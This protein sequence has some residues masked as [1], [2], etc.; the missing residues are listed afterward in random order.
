MLT[1]YQ[2]GEVDLQLICQYELSQMSL[3]ISTGEVD[4]PDLTV[5]MWICYSWWTLPHPYYLLN[6]ANM[7]SN[8]WNLLLSFR[9]CFGVF[10]GCQ[11]GVTSDITLPC[12]LTVY[13]P[14]YS[15]IKRNSHLYLKNPKW[16]P[17]TSHNIYTMMHCNCCSLF[18]G[19]R[20]ARRSRGRS[21]KFEL[22]L[23]RRC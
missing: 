1:T 19:G 13:Y 11:G 10:Q 16:L 17:N 6:L 9:E 5:E 2:T 20:S 23:T 21:A 15:D 3:N 18:L 14:N 4:L 7:S 12:S 22:I 8:T